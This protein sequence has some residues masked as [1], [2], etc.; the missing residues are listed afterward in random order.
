MMKVLASVT[1]VQLI[2][3][4]IGARKAIRGRIAYNLPLMQG[5]PENVAR[6]MWTMGS[7]LAAPW[8]LLAA[9]AAGA[10][11]LLAR[12]R[13]WLRRAVG[14]LGAVYILGILGERV[15]RE[16]FRHPD[17]KTTPLTASGIALSVAMA[18]LG[19][20]GRKRRSAAR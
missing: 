5:K 8:P 20:A 13:T 6:D 18:L 19:L 3:Q 14:W 10:V 4:L 9:H 2:V 16:S 11:L 17:S 1:L 15:T 12:P 7:G